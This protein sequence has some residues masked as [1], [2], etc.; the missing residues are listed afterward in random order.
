MNPM[1]ELPFRPGTPVSSQNI[2]PALIQ[3]MLVA[4]TNLQL[5]T[6]TR[7]EPVPQDPKIP[8]VPMFNGNKN[9]YSVFLALIKNYFSMQPRHYDTDRKKIGYVISRLEGTA[10]DWAV[11]ILE[12]QDFGTNSLILSDWTTF[13]QAFSKFSDPFSKRNATDSLLS[14]TQG[15]S[16]SVLAYWTKF[17]ALLYVSDIQPGSARPLFERGL[18]YEIRERLV[19]KNLPDDLDEFAMAVVDLDNRLFRLRSERRSSNGYNRNMETSGGTPWNNAPPRMPQPMELGNVSTQDEELINGVMLSNSKERLD[20]IRNMEPDMRRQVCVQEG[21][22]HYCKRLVGSPPEHVAA[23]CPFKRNKPKSDYLD[24]LPEVHPQ[25]GVP[26]SYLEGVPKRQDYFVNFINDR[27]NSLLVKK[28]Y[29]KVEERELQTPIM[30][31]SGAMGSGYV[32]AQFVKDFKLRVH[33]LNRKIAVKSIDGSSCGSGQIEF[34]VRGIVGWEDISE[35]IDL[36][37]IESPR[38]P[39]VLG[40][41]WFQKNNPQINWCTSEISFGDLSRKQVSKKQLQIEG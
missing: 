27:Q 25:K 29:L 33:T 3:Q 18:K 14:L 10:A 22:C 7:L 30:F 8:D 6:S 38:H 13:I 28:G 1:N 23:N 32:D 21:R 2:D 35:E 19:D 4:L 16:Q 15:K 39:V 5:Q 20:E 12:N 26:D 34:Y 36:L 40:Y 37:V 24:V 31:D 11:T 17:S 41:Q 9:Q